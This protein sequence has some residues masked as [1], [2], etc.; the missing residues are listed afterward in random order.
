MEV[1]VEVASAED[2]SWA[3]NGTKAAMGWA[4]AT[5]TTQEVKPI[6]F[7]IDFIWKTSFNLLN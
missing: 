6:F 2:G 5:L 4:G 3:G 1:E 7:L